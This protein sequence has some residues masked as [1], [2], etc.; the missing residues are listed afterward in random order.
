[1]SPTKHTGIWVGSFWISLVAVMVTGLVATG[2]AMA[3]ATA[4]GTD[5]CGASGTCGTGAEDSAFGLDALESNTSGDA[6]TAVG[7]NALEDNSS[8]FGNTATGNGALQANT[9]GGANTAMGFQALDGTTGADNTA[10]GYEALD[11]NTTGNANT[12][13]G[14]EALVE[15]TG[16][17]N[18]AMGTDALENLTSGDNNIAVGF[19]AG[20]ALATGSSNNI[21]IGASGIDGESNTTR[22]GMPTQTSAYIGGVFGAFGVKNGL[23]ILIGPQG[24]L[25]TEVSSV[26]FKRDVHDMGNASDKLMKL[27]PVTF[28]YRQDPDNTPRYGLIAEEVEKVYPEMVVYDDKGQVEGVRYDQLPAMLLNQVQKLTAKDAAQ[29]Q[30]I[31]VQQHEIA[32]LTERMDAL[33]RQAR[34]AGPEHLASAMR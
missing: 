16:G 2:T 27:R 28:R 24:H 18:T 3:Q 33:E 25:Y 26:R 29:K 23:P 22:I 1:M 19:N 17:G 8:G 13:I 12:A 5:A 32:L 31:A 4:F 9:T 34:L 6:N 10:I 21:D 11:L 15:S 30:Q 20:S 7:T 14:F